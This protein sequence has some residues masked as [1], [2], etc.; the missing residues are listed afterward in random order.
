MGRHDPGS[1]LIQIH[2]DIKELGFKSSCDRVAA[3]ARV[4]R[5]GQADRVNSASKRTVPAPTS[6]NPR[7]G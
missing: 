2:E 1:L 5:A 3:F 4:W 6:E 7:V